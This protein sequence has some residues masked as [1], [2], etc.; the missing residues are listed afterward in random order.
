MSSVAV[1]N[2][3]QLTKL[4]SVLMVDDQPE[5]CHLLSLLAGEQ[6][7][8]IEACSSDAA[9]Q[10]LG[11]TN[12]D[13]I[14]SD[15][16]MPGMN[17]IELLRRAQSVRPNAAR[18]LISGY[19][20]SDDIIASI[21][22]GH[23]LYF[24]RKPFERRT[25]QAILQQAAQHSRLLEDRARLLEE[26]T[27]LNY[28]LE[29]RVNQ[30]TL[31]LE[32][33]NSELLRTAE[34]LNRTVIEQA[35]LAAAVE[36][37]A[38]GIVMTDVSGTIQYVNPAFTVMTGYTREEAAGKNPRILKSGGESPAF[39]HELWK[40]IRSGQV[41][42]GELRNR[43]KDGTVYDE[44]MQ[45]SPVFDSNDK[46]VSYIAIKQNVTERRAAERGQAFLAAIVESSE[47]AILTYNPSGSILTWNRG[48]EAIFG[49]SSSEVIGKDISMLVPPERL[50]AL[51][52]TRE[53]GMQGRAVS[54]HH[55]LC[56][57]KDGRKFPISVSTCPIR[58]VAG[59][60]IAISNILRDITE[61]ERAQQALRDSEQK[62]RELAENIS[63]VIWVV[64]QLGDEKPY[65]SGAY[66]KIWG[67]SCESYYQNPTSWVEWVHPDDVELALLVFAPEVERK[68]A[69]AEFRILTPDGEEKWIRDR[70]FPVFDQAG[71][72]IRTIGIAEE[73]TARKRYEEELI[74]AR[75][76]AEAA[77][78]AK[79]RFLANMSHE[80][81]TPM[82]GVIGMIQLLMGT[83]L[84]PEQHQYADVAQTSGRMLLSLIDGILDL[85]KIEA[86]KVTLEDLEFNLRGTIE[87]VVQLMHVQACAKG[88][89]IESHVS[90]QIPPFLHGDAYRLRQVMTNLC[91][92]AIK[93]TEKGKVTLEASIKNQ[94]DN[95]TTLRFAITDTGIGIR[96]DRVAALFSPFTQADD[97]TTRKYGGTGLGL[98]ISKHLV[99]TMG[100][101]M[102]VDS[103]EGEDSTFWFTAM[104]QRVPEAAAL[105]AGVE[106]ASTS[107]Q[108]PPWERTRT[109]AVLP[110]GVPGAVRILVAEANA[111]NRIVALAQ[112]AKL[113]YK[114]DAVCD[115]A[116]AVQALERCR[117]DLVLMDCEMP[118]MDGF[119]ATRF[120]RQSN[121]Q[122]PVI[123]L[124]ASA[125]ST[126]RDRC[127][128][129][130]MNDFLSKPVELDQLADVL[131][132]WCPTLDSRGGQTADQTVCEEQ[133]AATFDAEAL[134]KRFMGDRQLAGFVIRGFVEDFPA[135]M[136]VMGKRLIEKDGRGVHLQA[137]TLKGSAATVSA[138]SLSAVAREMEHES[139]AGRLEHFDTLVSRACEEFERLK[140]TWEHAGWL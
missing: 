95:T 92:N 46:I 127:I 128:R 64:P 91:A 35:S 25:I 57:R 36:Q 29:H 49:Y 58:N 18:I 22:Q 131:A 44:E 125:M 96:P 75:E 122:I 2:S 99:E 79:S 120:I 140:T 102:G 28:E 68:A 114:A 4:P 73:I 133:A 41:W 83:N 119:Q 78:Q 27:C 138:C 11:D 74:H 5:V 67:R 15:L 71:Q 124:T 63:Q 33:K 39:Y 24:I 88:L 52:Y 103:R 139:N 94:S 3:D 65:V 8:C 82:N 17:G 23:I 77:N 16:R 115:G 51:A 106:P 90:P 40:T 55:G 126:D 43:R 60:V 19:S 34:K 123:A 48:A 86:G 59:E 101:E 100:G 12:V 117:Y 97:S 53:E 7:Q 54:Q 137:H 66:E 45:I 76:G 14:V 50:P 70:A 109:S 85:S 31:D 107:Q 30:R 38:D 110:G 121:S 62:F 9:M 118:V 1:L 104:L 116:R 134:L 98:A 129:E 130:G 93:F 112:L 113:N 13:V 89:R 135:R 10:I 32:L 108:K 136:N 21:N 56:L 47:D 37:A 69:E 111:T 61:R 81:R 42:H 20:E 6:Y 105:A 84:T 26:L 72:L 132:R 80:I 87:D